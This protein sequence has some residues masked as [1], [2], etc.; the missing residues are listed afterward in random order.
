MRFLGNSELF[1]EDQFFVNKVLLRM[2][3]TLKISVVLDFVSLE[4]NAFQAQLMG[5][6]TTQALTKKRR[7]KFAQAGF[8]S[9]L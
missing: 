4:S 5:N 9:K 3:L 7:R 6:I 8:A 2:I 1:Y